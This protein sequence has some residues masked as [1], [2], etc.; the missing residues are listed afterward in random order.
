MIEKR[1]LQDDEENQLCFKTSILTNVKQHKTLA[2][3]MG[4]EAFALR[5]LEKFDNDMVKACRFVAHLEEEVTDDALREQ[6]KLFLKRLYTL[7]P[8]FENRMVLRSFLNLK[9]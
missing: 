8:Q 5:V 3:K 6:C 2:A 1:L 7:L 4:P 9:D